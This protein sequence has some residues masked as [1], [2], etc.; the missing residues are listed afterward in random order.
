M[1]SN[2]FTT[3]PKNNSEVVKQVLNT[4]IYTIKRKSNE[5]KA[6]SMI[7]SLLQDLEEDHEFLHYIKI[8]DTRLKEDNNIVDVQSDIDEVVPTEVG[9]ALNNV[10]YITS[11]YLGKRDGYFLIKEFQQRIGS[12]YYS[13]LR[14][15]GI[16]LD[17]LLLELKVATMFDM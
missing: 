2:D 11:R 3:P 13:S 15:M 4:L 7:N 1:F 8:K 16:D 14:A 10:I 12:N 17:L 9:K 5:G 6:V